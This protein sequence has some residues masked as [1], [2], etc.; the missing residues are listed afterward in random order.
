MM[1][2]N[3][4]RE[5][6]PQK[7]G[8][9]VYV[10]ASIFILIANFIFLLGTNRMAA[11][12]EQVYESNLELNN[13]SEYLDGVQSS[14]TEYLSGRSS[15]GLEN[16]YRSEQEYAALVEE[17]SDTVSNVS[18]QR[19]ERDIKVM[20][21]QY[22]EAASQAIE[23]KRG[24]N[25]EK[26]RARYEDATERYGYINT[27]IRSL[28]M[29]QFVSNSE[30]YNRLSGSFRRFEY[31]SMFLMLFVITVSIFFI[32]KENRLLIEAHL[33]DAKLKYLM[34]QINP[35]FLFNTLNAGA[36]LAMM[37][38]ADRT[39]RY[40]QQVA[41]FYRYNVKKENDIVTIREEM[42]LVDNYIYILNVRFS[43]DIHYEKEVKESLYDVRMP[44]MI[45][46]PIVENCV[47]HGIHE[48]EGS[49][50]I[51]IRVYEEEGKVC[52]S[53]RDNGAGMSR[54]TI[55]DILSGN[56]KGNKKTG[57]SN[58]VGMDNVLTRLKLYNGFKNVADIF[59]DG[60]GTGTEVVIYLRKE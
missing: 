27:Y 9:V 5:Y 10:L 29:Q 23:A 15:E 47:N 32:I 33:K 16:Y 43:G 55:D 26:Y 1:W 7:K 35:H 20:S 11:R 59:S 40:V 13:L 25:V 50:K 14:M 45:L 48:M 30:D 36:Q 46:Q 6:S 56:F 22:L 12:L 44:S 42:E 8:T 37:E 51:S 60:D 18:F 38:G 54:E 39:Y 2:K 41:L 28:N 4:F 21:G 52:I 31:T 17:L 34:A 24:R 53:I 49:G 3:K 57:A 19:M 58:G